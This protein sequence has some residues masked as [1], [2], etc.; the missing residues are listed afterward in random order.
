MLADPGVLVLSVLGLLGVSVSV[1]AG[2]GFGIA[3]TS[4]IRCGAPIGI[5][6][7]SLCVSA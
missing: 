5:T 1:S 6:G 3:T 4:A 7:S 2:V